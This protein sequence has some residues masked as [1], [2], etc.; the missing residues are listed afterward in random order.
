[1][2]LKL[3]AT[4]FCV[5]GLNACS[6]MPTTAD[7]GV[8][9]E[10]LSEDDYTVGSHLPQRNKQRVQVIDQNQL[11]TQPITPTDINGAAAMMNHGTK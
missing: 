8:K 6:S 2:K 4:M 11:A 5:A 9:R 10:I 7:N 3:L 1:M